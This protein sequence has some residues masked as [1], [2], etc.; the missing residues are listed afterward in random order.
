MTLHATDLA[1]RPAG[2]EGQITDVTRSPGPFVVVHSLTTVAGVNLNRDMND[3]PK[4]LWHGGI[5][6]MRVS[7]QSLV[8]AARAYMR[9]DGSHDRISALS[10]KSLPHAVAQ[11]LEAKHNVDP[12]DAGPA[13]ALIVAA[14]GLGVS[15][16]DPGRTKVMAYVSEDSAQQLSRIVI[17]HWDELAVQRERVEDLIAE[18]LNAAERG[19]SSRRKPSATIPAAGLPESVATA[20]QAVLEPGT[21]EEIALFGRMLAGI[22]GGRVVSAAHVAHGFGIEP[23]HLITDEFTAG[24]DYQDGGVFMRRWHARTPVPG[25]GHFLPASGA[26]PAPT[27]HD[28]GPVRQD[29]GRGR[30]PGPERRA[31]VD[32][33]D[34]PQPAFGQ[35]LPH[36]LPASPHPGRGH[37]HRRGADRLAR[38]RGRD[39]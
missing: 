5:E 11:H 6:R 17:S 2:A 20:A 19:T 28:A 26:G 27:P 31:Q 9:T 15:P 24:D 4:T 39:P 38:L 33:G 7:A 32:T 3:L 1:A 18:A 36:R 29:S 34:R 22:P 23:L 10:T 16:A 30:G 35:A 8:R 14:T 13:A 25:L 37:H 21:V 12:A